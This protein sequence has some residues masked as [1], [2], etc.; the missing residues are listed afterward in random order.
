MVGCGNRAQPKLARA[1]SNRFPST[2]P[3]ADPLPCDLAMPATVPSHARPPGF[4]RSFSLGLSEAGGRADRTGARW[5][6]GAYASPWNWARWTRSRHAFWVGYRTDIPEGRSRGA[7]RPRESSPKE[8]RKS[9]NPVAAPTDI[10]KC[11]GGRI[12]EIEEHRTVT[13]VE[14][15]IFTARDRAKTPTSEDGCPWY[16]V[17]RCTTQG[18]APR[19]LGSERALVRLGLRARG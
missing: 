6:S 10:P 12:R 15:A 13:N 9:V 4:R 5:K 18:D 1:T 8:R 19:G 16:A 11:V 2:P 3:S 17:P 7:R 14:R